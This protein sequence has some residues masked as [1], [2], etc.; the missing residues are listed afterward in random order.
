MILEDNSESIYIFRFG[1]L[2]DSLVI[3]P[4]LQQIYN[5]YQHRMILI[6]N[7][8][9]IHVNTWSV[10]KYTMLFKKFLN[11]NTKKPLS[12]YFLIK[13]I[14]KDKNKKI[15]YYLCEK[16]SILQVIRDY[17]FFKICGFS[18]IYGINAVIRNNINK[19]KKNIQLESQYLYYLKLIITIHNETNEYLSIKVPLLN[20]PE[21]VNLKI[22]M[23]I[24]HLMLK[25]KVLIAIGFGSKMPAK[26]W[27]IENYKELIRKIEN[28]ND[29]IYFILFGDKNEYKAGE[30]IK[31]VNPKKIINIS[32]ETSI[33]ES[34]DFLSKCNLL[35]SNDTGIMHLGSSMGVKTIAIFSS[36]DIE[37]KWNPVGENNIIFRKNIECKS[38]MLDVC[39]KN[40]LCLRMI[41]VEDVFE[42]VIFMLNKYKI[43]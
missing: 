14:R 6:T 30:L 9:N 20:I 19:L 1:N 13:N 10:L 28:I 2:G 8:E 31:L 3:I 18:K 40:N 17:I 37:G 24:N 25:D 29:K 36:I 39:P 43:L 26:R 5:I 35:I 42:S 41:N 32:G 33:I 12:L 15:L 7:E 27:P 11:Y 38:C 21:R 16:R 23:L 22:N 34:A 4:A